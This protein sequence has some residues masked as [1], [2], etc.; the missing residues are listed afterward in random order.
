MPELS[1]STDGGV[2]I[3]KSLG[4]GKNDLKNLYNRFGKYADK[5]PGMNKSQ[6]DSLYNDLYNSMD[7]MPQKT[8]NGRNSTKSNSFNR[9]KY[10]K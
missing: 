10:F 8:L 6:I 9:S 5:I 3:L 7:T 1:K 2:G 4:M